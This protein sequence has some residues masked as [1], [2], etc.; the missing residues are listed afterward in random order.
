MVGREGAAVVAILRDAAEA[1]HDAVSALADLGSPG[2]RPG[3][4]DADEVADAA[5][6]RVLLAAGLGVVSEESGVLRTGHEVTVVLDPVDGS[7]NAA[8]GLDLYATSLCAIDADGPLAAVVR[9]LA[10]GTTYE[11]LRGEGATRGWAAIGPSRCRSLDEAVVALSGH[12]V[13][14]PGASSRSLGVASL[15]LCG[16]ADGTFDAFIDFDDDHHHLWDLAGGMFVCAEAGVALADVRGRPLWPASLTERRSILAAAR[17]EL[18]DGCR[19]FVDENGSA[20][21]S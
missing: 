12:P 7:I 11:A 2:S 4:T 14:R 8:R 15:A 18:L 1:V 5:A 3:Q 13:C 9:N 17:A 16:V 10:T 21:A 6:I 19:R 20:T